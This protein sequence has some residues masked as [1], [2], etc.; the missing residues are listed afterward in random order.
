MIEPVGA[1]AMATFVSGQGEYLSAQDPFF[2]GKVAMIIDGEWRS[3]S[4]PRSPRTSSGVS[5]RLPAASPE[6]EN[7]TQVTASTLFIPAN[8]K[9]KEEAATFLAYLVSEE[10]MEKFAVALGNL[11]GRTSLAGSA[12]LRQPA[13]LRRVGRRGILPEREGAREPSVQRRVCHRPRHR[14]R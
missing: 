6:L 7:S 5:R 14:L 12:A 1:Q 8:S 11:P 10:P 9:H 13:G 4:A 3:A 2:S